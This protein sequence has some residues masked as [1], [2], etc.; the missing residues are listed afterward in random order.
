[1]ILMQKAVTPDLSA[2]H[3]TQGYDRI[4]GYVVR[5]ADVVLKERR[6]LVLLLRETPLHAGH[7]RLMSEVTASGA[8]VMPPVPAFYA[9]PRSVADIVE[10]TTGRALDL[11]DV[12]TEAVTRWTGERGAGDDAVVHRL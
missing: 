12:D 5:A 7:L 3:L 1:M 2:A 8:V 10:H 6:R 4:G 11:L 9:R